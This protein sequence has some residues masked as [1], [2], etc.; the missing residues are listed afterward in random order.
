MKTD[1][2]GPWP[3]WTESEE[4]A[5]DSSALR[6]RTWIVRVLALFLSL[7][8]IVLF[9]GGILRLIG[10]PP[11]GL[12]YESAR[13]TRDPEIQS[14]T[15]SV[16]AVSAEDRAGTGFVVYPGEWIVTNQHIIEDVKTVKISFPEQG[17]QIVKPVFQSD[18]LDLAL[19]PS[20]GFKD[21]GLSLA[22][23]PDYMPGSTL[24]LIGNPLG[25]FRVVTRADYVGPILLPDWQ[26]PLLAIQGA[27][28]RGNSGSPVLNENGEVVGLLFATVTKE[29][30]DDPIGLVISSQI[31]E[32][33][34]QSYQ[35]KQDI[36]DSE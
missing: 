15:E 31:I 29:T 24:Y 19:L 22:S 34:I 32:S 33:F 18:E 7:S 21:K 20:T 8:L 6:R 1:E 10:M 25:F 23:R 35:D 4:E 11:M 16:V 5:V 3:E 9:M 36:E 2:S 27:V 14:W 17:S 12:L 26:Q 28:Y 30:A 13:L